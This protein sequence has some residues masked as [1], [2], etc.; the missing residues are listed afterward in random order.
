MC[1]AFDNMHSASPG[2][3]QRLANENARA[4]RSSID[5]MHFDCKR[6]NLDVDDLNG[7]E[8]RRAT[9]FIP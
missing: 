6:M 9:T 8:H 5:E 2:P 1:A 7:H 4:R 3:V